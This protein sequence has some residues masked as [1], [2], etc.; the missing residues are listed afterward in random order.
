MAWK[1][2]SDAS[3]EERLLHETEQDDSSPVNEPPSNSRPSILLWLSLA[4]NATLLT[5]LVI[6]PADDII[7][8]KTVIFH[9]GLH[10][11]RTEYQ[12]SS[13][14]VN[15]NWEALYN[16][17]SLSLI[18]PSSASKL[19]NKTT[20]LPG[21]PKSFVIQLSVFHNFHC[22]NTLRKLLYPSKYPSPIHSQHTDRSQHSHPQASYE[23]EVLHLE[24]CIEGIRQSLQCSA[25]T[26]A[27][28]WEWSERRKMMVGNTAT[29]H[30]CKDWEKVRQWGLEHQ[31]GRYFDPYERVEGAP[32][33]D[34]SVEFGP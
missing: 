25:D 29:T 12:G 8:Y 16:N 24:H 4:L 22:L 31:T 13:D 28:F 32:I 2:P 3:D 20:H 33:R 5:A 17:M 15:A 21:D 9:S 19:L 14:E 7:S 26:S 11:D 10:L 6:T 30:T 1:S 23:E 18:P 34:D 27:L